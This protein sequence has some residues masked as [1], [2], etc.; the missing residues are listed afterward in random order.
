MSFRQFLLLLLFSHYIVSESLQPHG[1]QYTRLFCPP[2]SPRVCSNSC[3]LSW[4]CYL[5]ISN[6]RPLLLLPSI[7][8]ST[9]VMSNEE[10]TIPQLVEL[11]DTELWML[12]VDY[13]TWASVDFPPEGL[14]ANAPWILR[15]DNSCLSTLFS[16][17]FLLSA[18]LMAQM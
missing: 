11:M 9:R 15:D 14:W 8:P 6:C 16:T 17:V 18:P 5:I 2:L 4:W 10:H 13:R 1:L 7:F 12:R 3:P